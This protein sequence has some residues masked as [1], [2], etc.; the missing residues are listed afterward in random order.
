MTEEIKQTTLDRIP[1]MIRTVY[2][3]NDFEGWTRTPRPYSPGL[4]RVGTPEGVTAGIEPNEFS[5]T[6]LYL[7]LGYEDGYRLNIDEYLAYPIAAAPFELPLQLGIVD[8]DP[9]IRDRRPSEPIGGADLEDLVRIVRCNRLNILDGK[10]EFRIGG[11]FTFRFLERFGN[12][13]SADI[14]MQASYD[15]GPVSFT[16]SGIPMPTSDGIWLILGHTWLMIPLDPE[17]VLRIEREEGVGAEASRRLIAENPEDERWLDGYPTDIPEKANDHSEGYG[18]EREYEFP[19]H[20]L[21]YD[22]WWGSAVSTMDQIFDDEDNEVFARRCFCYD[23]PDTLEKQSRCARPNFL[24][25]P[26]G[27]EV[28]WYQHPFKSMWMNQPLSA[29]EVEHLMMICN[30]MSRGKGRE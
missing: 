7:Y 23:D 24:F 10:T 6:G 3:R 11:G 1:S 14:A 13:T 9:K 2:A 21:D 22:E 19:E 12:D 25:K 16:L 17:L 27:F 26:T 4:C 18:D 5:D 28:V 20:F 15:G 8:F 30:G 29:R